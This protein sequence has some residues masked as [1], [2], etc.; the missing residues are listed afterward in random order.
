MAHTMISWGRIT[1]YA[2]VL[3]LTITLSA[4]LYDPAP[5]VTY[6][7]EAST[8]EGLDWGIYRYD[9]RHQGIAPPDSTVDSGLKPEW[10]TE[11]LNRGE[12]TAS[13]SSP[14]VDGENL[15]IGLDTRELVAVDRVTGLVK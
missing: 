10:R 3:L 4:I 7:G 13:K 11:R 5:E 15:Y 2:S 12:Y 6:F 9:V 14:A 8:A 1:S